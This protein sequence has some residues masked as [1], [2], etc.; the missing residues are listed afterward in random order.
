MQGTI[1]HSGWG[2]MKDHVHERL[3]FREIDQDGNSVEAVAPHHPSPETV[4][5][6]G[7]AGHRNRAV[8]PFVVAL[9]VLVAGLGWFGLWAFGAGTSSLTAQPESAHVA[10]LLMSN[11]PYAILAAVIIAAALLF[12]HAAQWQKRRDSLAGQGL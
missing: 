9:W 5:P 4:R 12:W 10:F 11:A 6:S 1:D 7:Q 3:G 8:N 2:A